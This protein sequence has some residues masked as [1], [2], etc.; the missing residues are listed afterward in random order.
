MWKNAHHIQGHVWH[1]LIARLRG[2][3]LVR[4]SISIW[5]IVMLSLNNCR[6]QRKTLRFF[7]LDE[8]CSQLQPD[9]QLHGLQ[10][11]HVKG[12]NPGTSAQELGD[13]LHWHWHDLL[14]RVSTQQC[15]QERS[16]LKSRS[17]G[18][19]LKLFHLSFFLMFVYGILYLS[20]L[21][22]LT[23]N[24]L[25]YVFD[26]HCAGRCL[27]LCAQSVCSVVYLTKCRAGW[28]LEG[29]HHIN[30]HNDRSLWKLRTCVFFLLSVFLGWEYLL[31]KMSCTD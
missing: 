27:A 12:W 18:S 24:D 28:M 2:W 6:K 5:Q 9:K 1:S 23:D 29:K 10:K 4:N 3:C 21:L 14:H 20:S 11:L 16:E 25:C 7:W 31:E 17:L 22:F 26:G 8:T 19:C 15:Q 13:G 30:F